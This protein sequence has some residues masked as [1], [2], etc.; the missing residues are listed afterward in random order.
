MPGFIGGNWAY[1]VNTNDTSGVLIESTRSRWLQEKEKRLACY[2]LGWESIKV[3]LLQQSIA[4][5]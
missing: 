1:A 4:E 5:N 3:Y 2:Y